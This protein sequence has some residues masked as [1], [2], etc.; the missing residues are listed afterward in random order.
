MPGENI[1]FPL[2]TV[3]S[4]QIY[5]P[6]SLAWR[7]ENLQLTSE[8]TLAS[9][10][11]PAPYIPDYGSGYPYGAL[12]F[13]VFHAL[14]E[15]GQRD[16]TL[17]RAGTRLFAHRGWTRS[18]ETLVTG[19]SADANAKYPDVF[20]EVAGKIVWSNGVDAPLIYD[21]YTIK[22]L[23][24]SQAPGAPSVLGPAAGGEGAPIFRNQEGY[25]HPGRLGRV[26]DFFTDTPGS[27]ALL[28]SNWSYYV[29]FEDVFGDRSAFSP[30]VS[31]QVRQE[32]ATANCWPTLSDYPDVA[33]LSPLGTDLAVTLDDLTRQ[34]CLTSIPRGPQHTM[35]RVLYRTNANETEPHF[36]A[37]IPD[38]VTSVWPDNTPDSGLGAP[39]VEYIVTPKFH[40]ACSYQGRLAIAIGN[41][42][43]LSDVGFPG[44]FPRDQFVDVEGDIT[45]LAAFGGYLYAF[46]EQTV[47]RLEIDAEGLRRRPVQSGVGAS[48]PSSVVATDSGL[49]VWLGSSSWYSMTM[50][51][52]IENIGVPEERLFKRLNPADLSRSVAVW[53]PNTKEYLCAVPEAGAYGNRLIMAWDGKGWRRQRHGNTYSSFCVTKDWRR[54]VLAA[55]RRIS[56]GENN[57]WVLDHEVYGYTPPTKTYKYQSAW[58]RRDPTGRLRFNM[59][60]VYVG[61]VEAS[62]EPVTWRLWRDGSRDTEVASGTLTLYDPD[63]PSTMDTAVIGTSKYRNP[64][65]TWFK[66]DA[67][68]IDAQSFAF[69]LECAEPTYINLFGFSFDSHSTDE[70]GAR[71]NR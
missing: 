25:S 59:D 58:I 19:L 39:G 57:V 27:G 61:V 44:S 54:Y 1:G 10:R 29:Q 12:V 13:G 22:D 35:A 56:N 62:D 51:E 49:L 20:V 26:G 3:E 46:T 24:F 17:I 36:L 43:R 38:N 9:V 70:Q 60:T 52:N 45:A 30:A 7:I 23:G 18:L 5:A 16:V 66:F 31:M 47:F 33:G 50:D 8:G 68:L 4:G 11:G 32:Y 71:V 65:L 37:R 21:G 63:T 48:G 53:N 28:D 41:R 55:G 14:I 34:L 15:N 42:V 69:D 64:R 67:R 2:P 40:I 6:A